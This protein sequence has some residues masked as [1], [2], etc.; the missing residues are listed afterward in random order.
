MAGCNAIICGGGDGKIPCRPFTTVL[1]R[2]LCLSTGAASAS[3]IVSDF[4]YPL[5]ESPDPRCLVNPRLWTTAFHRKTCRLPSSLQK[6]SPSHLVT[7]YVPTSQGGGSFL[8]LGCSISTPG[9][10]KGACWRRAACGW[11]PRVR[12]PDRRQTRWPQT[13][14]KRK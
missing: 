9:L 6:E 12:R 1:L 10:A 11:R 2:P 14:S 3:K 4:W 13:K 7:G 5:F 8:F